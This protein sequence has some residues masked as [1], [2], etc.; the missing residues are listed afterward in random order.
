MS[1]RPSDQSQLWP[2]AYVRKKKKYPR[3]GKYEPNSRST[4]ESRTG[5]GRRSG[6]HATD[7]AERAGIRGAG[8]AR[9]SG[10]ETAGLRSGS[11]DAEFLQSLQRGYVAGPLPANGVDARPE[12][13]AVH[14]R[15]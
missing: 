1:S 14:E 6:N 7:R 9:G 15:R 3:K 13:H 10:S 5:T 4:E 8:I 11:R 2:T 12:H